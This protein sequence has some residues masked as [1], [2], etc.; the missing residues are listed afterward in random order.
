M[1]RRWKRPV[2]D[3]PASAPRPALS[4]PRRGRPR[5]RSPEWRASRPGALRAGAKAGARPPRS[6]GWRSASRPPSGRAL[7]ESDQGLYAAAAASSRTSSG[8]LP[9]RDS[10]ALVPLFVPLGETGA[11]A[12]RA[13]MAASFPST[14]EVV[15]KW[16]KSLL[17]AV[18]VALP[19][20]AQ[21]TDHHK[22]VSAADLKWAPVPSLPKG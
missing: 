21:H 19:A 8:A 10:S 15:M 9:R 22:A 4:A 2:F 20:W 13:P 6:C 17:L 16:R 7:P 1:L 12:G 5:A 18:L 14:K 11:R 3:R